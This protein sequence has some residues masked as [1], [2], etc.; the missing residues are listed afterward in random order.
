MSDRFIT[1]LKET[2]EEVASTALLLEIT[3]GHT[4][5]QRY[6]SA[7]DYTAVVSYSGALD[8][9][10]CLSGPLA[11]VVML[12]AALLGETRETMDAELQDAFAELCNMVAGGVQTRIEPHFGPIHMSTPV[13]IAGQ[14]HHIFGEQKTAC[15]HHQFEVNQHPFFVEIFYRL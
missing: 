15:I 11:A 14:G 4:E 6:E 13:V 10:L 3:P 8:G 7:S 2:I 12:A 5:N 9:S 1:A